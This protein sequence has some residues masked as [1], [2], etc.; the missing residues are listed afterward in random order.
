MLCIVVTDRD[1]TPVIRVSSDDAT[2]EV[3]LATR[4]TFLATFTMATDQA[5]KLGLGKNQS[6]VCMY[7][8]YQVFEKKNLTVNIKHTVLFDNY[9]YN[10]YRLQV[11]QLNKLPLIVTFIGTANCNTGHI[12][13]LESQ[14]DDYLDE[15]KQTVTE[16]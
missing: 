2:P 15:I 12:L 5:S 13:A 6:I 9:V 14:I 4:P 3:A 1:G 16:A 7:S 11:I 8:N 10:L